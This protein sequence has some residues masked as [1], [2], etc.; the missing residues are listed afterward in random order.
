VVYIGVDR[1][2]GRRITKLS[3]KAKCFLFSK[4]IVTRLIWYFHF[5]RFHA[6]KSA[7]PYIFDRPHPSPYLRLWNLFHFSTMF[8]SLLNNAFE[9]G[10]LLV[11]LLH[12][13]HIRCTAQQRTQCLLTEEE[14]SI[15]SQSSHHLFMLVLIDW[16]IWHPR[17]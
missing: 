5:F 9:A 3:S 6:K 4:H 17:A 1:T 13:L 14:R 12:F 11:K 10:Y 15:T 8:H 2:V 16:L 7:F